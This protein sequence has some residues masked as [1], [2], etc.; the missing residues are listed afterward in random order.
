MSN[1]L[2][3]MLGLRDGGDTSRLKDMLGLAPKMASGGAV[4]MQDGG[5]LPPGIKRATE[6]AKQSKSVAPIPGMRGARQA[7]QGYLG[8]DPSYSVMDPQAE[9]LASAYR[10]G[11]ATSVLGDIAG[12]LSPFAYASA[13]SKVGQIPGASMA[14]RRGSTRISPEINL[15]MAREQA[16]KIGQDPSPLARSLQ[17]GYEH[18]WYHGTTGDIERFRKDLLGES[19]GAESAKKGFFFARDPQNPPAHMLIKAPADSKSVELLRKLGIPED[20]IA[21]LNTVS[22]TGHG[23]ET[24]SGYSLLGG[25]REYK[26]AM[27]K[28]N[29]ALKKGNLTEY[30]RELE[31]A[32]D[33]AISDQRYRQRLVARFGEA[34]DEMLDS[35]Q[36]AIYNKQ[37]PQNEAE[38]LDKK[39]KE[40]MPYGWYTNYSPEQI[41]TLKKEIT[42]LAGEKQAE[43]ALSK[44]D[45]FM[46]VRNE[47]QLVDKTQSG[48]NVMPVAL[49]YKNP[50]VYDFQ[51]STYRDTTYSDLVDQA[52]RQGNDALILKNTYDPGA[53]RSQLIDVGVV[54]NP[55]Q[56]R[57]KFAAF[58]PTRMKESDIL[59]GVGALGAGLAAPKVAQQ[60]DQ[61]NQ[62]AA[63]QEP[64]MAAGG[65][66]RMQDG[67]SMFNFNPMAAKAA[68]QKQMRE[69]TP[70]TPL[71]ALSRG[72]ATGLFGSTEEQVPYTGSIMEGSPERQ[73]SQANLRELGRN[74]GAM[75]DIGGM[76]TPFAKPAA[77]AVTRGA[78][79]LGKAGLEQVD[80]A[81][82]GEGPLAALVAPAAP[83]QAA[84]RVQ[85]PKAA[86]IPTQ[87]VTYET[88]TEGPFY[89]VRPSVS[90]APAGQRRGTLESDGTQA[91]YAVTGRAGSDVPQPITNEAVQQ[92]MADPAN[93]VRRSADTYS[94][95]VLGKPYELPDVPESSI[96]KQAPIGR[97]FMLAATDDPAYKKAIFEQYARQMPDVVKQSGARNYDELL[98][99]SYRQMA[100]E[101]DEQFK[102]LP[103][104]L[105]YHRAG[106]GNYRNS[107]QMLQD[108]YGNKHLYV[109]QGGDEHPYLKDVDPITG[110][111]ENEKF[112]AVHDFFGHAIH[113]NEFGPKGEEI[114]WAAH[115]QMYSPL[116]RLAMSTETRGQNSTV[117]YTPL[118]AALKRT[119]NELNMQRYE[120][121]R[122][123]KT[124]LVK[125]IDGQLKEAWNGFQF[126]PQKPLLLPPEFLNPRYEGSMPDYLRPLIKPDPS[127]TISTPMLHFSKQ[128]GLTETD[129]AFYGT[130]IKG[131]EAARLG[132]AGAIRPRTYFYAGEGVTPEPGLGPNRYRAM[133]ENLYDLAADPLMLNMLA[134]ETTRI[135]MTASSN[136][137]LAQPAEAT[138]ALERLI[139]DYG[140]AGYISPQST[141]PS[142]VL[143]GK[144]PVTPYKQGGAVRISDDLDAMLLELTNAPKMQAGGAALKA[145]RD[146]LEA[147]YKRSLA[148]DPRFKQAPGQ[149]TNLAG[150]SYAQ[151]AA[152]QQYKHELEDA[153]AK[154]SGAQEKK[155]SIQDL[156][157]GSRL[158]SIIGDRTQAD[159]I[160]RSVNETPLANEVIL[161]GGPRFGQGK[162]AQGKEDFWASQAQAAQGVQN[163]IDA[164][165][166]R[167]KGKPVIGVYTAMSAK[168]SDMYAKHFAES[169]IEQY[170]FTGMTS[171]QIDA[172]NKEFRKKYPQ[173]AGVDNPEFVDQ[174]MANT[175]M[176]KAFVNEHLKKKN[177]EKFNIPDGLATRHAITVPELRDVPTGLAGYSVGEMKPGMALE[178]GSYLEHPTYNTV[179]PGRFM[180]G[181][182]IMHDYRDLFP[183]ATQRMRQTLKNNPKFQGP[184]VRDPESQMFGTF[185]FQ[186]AEQEVT[187]K[188]IDE[189]AAREQLIKQL[190]I[191]PYKKGG[192]VQMSKNLN[193]IK[194]ELAMGKKGKRYA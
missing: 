186:G 36:K 193:T 101:T 83:L 114:A 140:Y 99:A 65:A 92:V 177:I 190:G 89:R 166:E 76:V 9:R 130:G 71:G 174:I 96:F 51:G 105:S 117:N 12:A 173:F 78:T 132:L 95:D 136:K 34:R 41:K 59:A 133:G 108:V 23:A 189:L 124:D 38:E 69:S 141:K 15:Q 68:K 56:I 164:A 6:R 156:P 120:A 157:V 192:K 187:Q 17:Q 19:T 60:L 144:I 10:T 139:R 18:D 161:H 84:P 167:A 128:A 104:S 46:S 102:R 64:E 75:T 85:A 158:V 61:S 22:M 110:L 82:F 26:E 171:K 122:R 55:N 28:S 33:I 138:N 81:M 90:Q 45:K 13:L 20:Q 152:E 42:N 98:A 168:D 181:L 155:M 43:S 148:K 32:E 106:E 160:L 149:V 123:G 135:P 163:R 109:F 113:G 125:E 25:S 131:E 39:V 180:G 176:R 142:A 52:I 63:P 188:L 86:T 153:L 77:Q 80:R 145:F 87:G 67:G 29:A 97:T 129:P 170:P 183:E 3:K 175:D 169:L 115:S 119:I 57:S 137:G 7:I 116:A 79:A 31:K 172:F 126:A 27:R 154:I 5:K 159:K 1:S 53:G 103:I 54:F 151:W 112:R 44:L 16:E 72:F 94:Q 143:F 40:L 48:S 70:E 107:K 58:D 127:T 178:K 88:T 146:Q 91:G 21:K 62:E 184:D 162:L 66:V 11:E 121:N 194:Y 111:N 2:K 50:L 24:A 4:H 179:I 147:Q 30:S 100:K 182:E 185:G 49:R 93:F 37:L 165:A 150:K 8:M 134:R 74:I 47:S 73:Q 191:L 35:I 118:N 14:V